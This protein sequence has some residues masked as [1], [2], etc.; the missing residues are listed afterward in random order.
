MDCKTTFTWADGQ[1]S[2]ALP[3]GQL[4]E[5]QEKADC[6]PLALLERMRNGTWREADLRQ[7][8]RLGLIGGGLE[9]TAALRM[10]ERYVYPARPLMEGLLPAQSILA[11]ALWGVE[12]DQPGK[13]QADGMA[14]PGL[15]ET[16]SSASPNSTAPEP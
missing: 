12:D 14:E 8:I 6:G 10:V 7:T 9:P 5:L 11:A 1:Y 13:D 3:L 16:E 2:F 15:A 4:E